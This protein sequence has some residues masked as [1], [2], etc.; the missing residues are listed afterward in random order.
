MSYLMGIT[1]TATFAGNELPT[2]SWS[3]DASAIILEFINSKTALHPVKQS[4]ILDASFQV[5]VD[6]DATNQPFAAPYSFV[7]GITLTNAKLFL[8]G[9]G[10]SNF[11]NFPSAIVRRVSQSSPRPGKIGTILYC[12]ASGTY[13]CPG[14]SPT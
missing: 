8:D 10:G 7:P 2:S 6:F 5:T 14:G 1:S 11:W 4:T 3:V 12:E 9:T 13:T